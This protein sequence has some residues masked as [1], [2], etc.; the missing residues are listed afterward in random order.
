M[1]I[2]DQFCLFHLRNFDLKR[3][4]NNFDGG[5]IRY[6]MFDLDDSKF[7]I[8]KKRQNKIASNCPSFSYINTWNNM[9]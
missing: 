9:E 6:P 7:E 8:A 2:V 5:K 3:N 1:V 4:F